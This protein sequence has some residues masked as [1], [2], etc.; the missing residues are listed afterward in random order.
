[1]WVLL[2][3]I[4][5]PSGATAIA[6]LIIRFSKQQEEKRKKLIQQ[7]ADAKEAFDIVNKH[8]DLMARAQ[9]LLDKAPPSKKV[10][11]SQK[12]DAATATYGESKNIADYMQDRIDQGLPG[13]EK[14]VKWNFQRPPPDIDLKLRRLL[15]HRNKITDAGAS[16]IGQ[17]IAVNATL[18]EVNL[19]YNQIGDVGATG[20]AMALLTN[21]TVTELNLGC[22]KIGAEGAKALA[23]A[24][25]ANSSLHSVLIGSNSIGC[26]GCAALAAALHFN[27]SVKQMALYSNRIGKDGAAA[28]A[29]ALDTNRSLVELNLGHNKIGDRGAAAMVS[30]DR[31]QHR[32]HVMS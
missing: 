7:K 13:E 22:N 30:G 9:M 19:G 6:T 2:C 29:D 20:V 26:E 23:A 5:G 3:I 32:C 1:M 10:E 24:L 18:V 25:Q 15:L 11:M 27:T 31:N 14:V 16:I 12:L 8:Y 28:L 21:K 4:P 17:A